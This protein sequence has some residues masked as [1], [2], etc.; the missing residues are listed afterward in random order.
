MRTVIHFVCDRR[1]FVVINLFTSV[2]DMNMNFIG[3][4][5]K[6]QEQKFKKLFIILEH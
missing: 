6:E 2:G 5:N 3:I 1:T 4:L